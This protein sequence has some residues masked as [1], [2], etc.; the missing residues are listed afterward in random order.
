[1]AGRHYFVDV[2]GGCGG[3]YRGQFL[4]GHLGLDA[5]SQVLADGGSVGEYLEG[6]CSAC[7]LPGYLGVVAKEL[8]EPVG[9]GSG[10]QAR[11]DGADGAVEVQEQVVGP[12]DDGVEVAAGRGWGGHVGNS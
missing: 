5:G 10:G 1:M 4:V 2:G 7:D 3:G 8:A 6:V 9:D 12:G 11:E